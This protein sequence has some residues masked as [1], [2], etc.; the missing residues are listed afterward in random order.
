MAEE[1][2][3]AESS[4]KPSEER[5]PG[6]EP[7]KTATATP[8]TKSPAKG[9]TSKGDM[10]VTEALK[11]HFGFDSFKGDQK[12]IIE[13]LLSGKDVFV[14]MPTGGGKS[15]CY[16]L[17][18]LM[19]EGTAI[20]ISPLIALMKNQVDAM[21]NFSEADGV[22]HFINSSLNRTAIEQVKQDILSGL[23]KLLYVAPESLTKE[24]N[25]EFL[26]QV[27]ISF[28][29]VDEAHCISEWGH[30]FRPEYRRIRPII[31]EIGKHPL[32][33]LTATATPKVQHDIQ[34]NLGML[35]ATV[36]KSSFN[37]SNLYYEVRPKGKD[38]DRE[39]IKYIKANEGKS[40]I[41][42]CLS[43][44]R[45]E[46][47]T[48]ILCA[49]GIK[50]L[51]Y[52]A[53]MDSQARSRNQDAFLMEE[54]DVIVATI[55]FGMGI[56]KPDVRYVIHYD[57]P[58]SLEGYYQE[59]GRAGRDG[60]EGRC[61]AFYA[62][63]D[64][65]KLEKFLQGKPIIEQE[66]GKQLLLETAAYAESAVCRRKVLLHYF[67]EEFTE[68]NC[69][70]C[71]NCL[72]PRTTVEGKELLVT[73]LEAIDLLRERYKAEHIVD[74]L[75][76]KE[77]ADI[78]S[79]QQNEMEQFGSGQEEDDKTWNAVLRQALIA[80]YLTKEIE[81]Y[82]TL[83]ITP[84]GREFMEHPTS[85]RVVK[86]KE[87]E[88]DEGADMPMRG[89]GASAVDPALF[90]IMK[91][92]RK[93]LSKQLDVPPFVIFQDPSLEA[94]A[95]TYPVTLEELQNIPGVGSGKAKRYGTEFV[96][97]IKKYVEENEIERP[98]DMRVRT[99]ANKSK[100]KVYIVQSIDRKVA[101]DDIASSKGLEFSE[102]LDEIESIVYSGTRINIDYFIFDAI[103]EDRVDDIYQYF[104]ESTTDSL[105]EAI[106]E[107]GSDYT[108][109]EIR[110]VRIKF[111]SEMAN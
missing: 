33:A 31:N 6:V 60:G 98:E 104:K 66:I 62:Y 101:L 96:A 3:K 10:N 83:R 109:D 100:L 12:A 74:F 56:D 35:D 52:H 105:Q 8:R 61:L 46:E 90:S 38:V 20:V 70:S 9:A 45:V 47:F 87:F 72:T 75:M 30:D 95:T 32:I 94:M 21:R 57:I 13:T 41:V 50:A 7:R 69:G 77:T 1:L 42:Y 92:L 22:A 67:G 68:E 14:L 15:L 37:R 29:A 2:P 53:G 73:A 110:L 58:K 11:K 23:T 82:G 40:G 16:Q 25:V 81:N 86:D 108:E 84:Q 39:I 19:M 107:L 65:Q 59:T 44:K 89:S 79:Y 24:E 91:D 64:L 54:A 18:S 36:F 27:K 106:E 102:L 78:V 43:R 5:K 4:K 88:E 76:G 85:F 48:D 80:G 71:D 51:P 111:L 17:P 34:K 49:N 26:R 63:K 93:K 99:V 55:A 103:D 97:L 28:Y